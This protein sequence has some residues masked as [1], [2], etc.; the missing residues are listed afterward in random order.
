[1]HVHMLSLVSDILWWFPTH[2]PCSRLVR[3]PSIIATDDLAEDHVFPVQ[4]RSRLHRD[5]ELRTWIGKCCWM[6]GSAE[7][8]RTVCLSVCL[9]IYLS[10][11]LSICVY[12]PPS[13]IGVAGY[14]GGLTKP[15]KSG[16]KRWGKSQFYP[17]R[18]EK[19]I[20]FLEGHRKDTTH[21]TKN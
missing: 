11:Y 1:M 20:I 4:G 10:I 7:S 21:P 16:V 6:V 3:S 2:Q 8:Y 13:G 18:P 12:E 9:S 15:D 5:E 17:S 14:L 19:N